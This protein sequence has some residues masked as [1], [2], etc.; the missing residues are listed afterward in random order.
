MVARSNETMLCVSSRQQA[1]SSSA[2]EQLADAR[3]ISSTSS[4]GTSCRPKASAN[5]PQLGHS[6]KPN[7]QLL[8]CEAMTDSQ[9]RVRSDAQL[10]AGIW[11]L[12]SGKTLCSEDPVS[13]HAAAFQSRWLPAL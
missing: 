1:A 8:R 13:T 5:S 7:M 3:G 10:I 12:A 6:S 4:S 11:L 9:A 2:N